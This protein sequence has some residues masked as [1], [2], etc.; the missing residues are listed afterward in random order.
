MKSSYLLKELFSETTEVRL[1]SKPDA[2][3]LKISFMVQAICNH[4]KRVTTY[5]FIIVVKLLFKGEQ[6]SRNL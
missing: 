4:T 1:N 2:L 3:M 6:E 5:N